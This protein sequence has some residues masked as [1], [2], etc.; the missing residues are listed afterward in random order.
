MNSYA[1]FREYLIAFPAN[2]PI[3]T[4]NSIKL[5]ASTLAQLTQATNQLTR[6][7][8][9]NKFSFFFLEHTLFCIIIDDCIGEM[10]SISS[11]FEINGNP[12][13]I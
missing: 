6:T 12:T 3:T 7:S 2:L 5:Q 4:L 9:V 10:L 1:N 8:S 13:F 11:R